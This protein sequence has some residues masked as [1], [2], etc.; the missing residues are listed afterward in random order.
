MNSLLHNEMFTGAIAILVHITFPVIVFVIASNMKFNDISR[1]IRRPWLLLKTFIV[2]CIMIPLITAGVVKILDVPL[3]LGGL[4]LIASVTAGDPFDVVEAKGKKGNIALS[5]IT[6]LFLVLVMPFTVPFWL[7]IFSQWFP[8][9]L[10]VS[11]WPL[12]ATVAPL[13]LVPLLAGIM[14]NELLPSLTKTLRPALEWFIKISLGIQILI[15]IVPAMEAVFTFNIASFAAIFIV[16]TLS[17]FAGYYAGGGANRKDRIS[18]ATTSALGNLAAIML[19]VHLSYP[20]V[21]VWFTLL[22]YI[23][24][25]WLVFMLWYL[26]LRV[27]LHLRGEKLE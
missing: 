22:A 3:L 24:L 18:I 6:M 14:L 15:F 17:L 26:F 19:V 13:T 20:K 8:L 27:K 21:H 2:A 16:T 9:R 11:P 10:S 7:W 5:S 25:R 4:L 1:E 12:F 23:I